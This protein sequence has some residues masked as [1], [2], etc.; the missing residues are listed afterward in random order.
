VHIRL[1]AVGDRQPSWVDSAFDDYVTRLPPQWRFQLDEI[2]TAT[3]RKSARPDSAKTAEAQ[4]IL[5]RVK[6]SEQVVLLDERGKQFTSRELA[7]RID[8]WQAVG[9]DVVFVIGGPDG[10]A[11]DIRKRANLVWSLSRLTLPHGLARVLYAEQMYRAWSLLSGHP[12]HRD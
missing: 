11:D 2:A 3:R 6:P 9:E 1:V 12:Y 10:V 7:D 8:Q 5:S 4:S